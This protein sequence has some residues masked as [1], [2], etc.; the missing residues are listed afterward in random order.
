MRD[1]KN[2]FY[3]YLEVDAETSSIIKWFRKIKIELM[4]DK[5]DKEILEEEN[6]IS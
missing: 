1:L 4:N 3:K 6:G 2:N 5:Y